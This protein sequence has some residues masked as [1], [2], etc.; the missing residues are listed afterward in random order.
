M[1]P[2][3]SRESSSEI[4]PVLYTRR[5]L[6]A[7]DRGCCALATVPETSHTSPNT[8]ARHVYVPSLDRRTTSSSSQFSG[9]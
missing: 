8:P 2:S 9:S 3:G 7:E 5:R 1:Y 6:P 4:F